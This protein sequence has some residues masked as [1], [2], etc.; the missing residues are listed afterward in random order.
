IMAK[1]LVVDVEKCSG[2]R[3]CEVACSWYQ[4]E[5]FNP[6]KARLSIVSWKKVAINYPMICEQCEKA[7]CAEVCP[8]DA[9]YKDALPDKSGR[10]LVSSPS[11]RNKDEE[12]G[13]WKVDEAKC[14]GCKF[15]SLVCPLGAISFFEE[16][17]GAI[18][19][20]LCDGDPQCVKYCPMDAIE[21]VEEDKVGLKKKRISA[22]K[23]FATM[24]EMP[25]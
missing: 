22:E 11:L 6:A 15:C 12:T 4:E 21:F 5:E 17:R 9:I 19:C 8:T 7:P 13:A 10:N 16:K 18:K 2:C 25:K 20:D 24:Q 1:I 14:I 23:L 3:I